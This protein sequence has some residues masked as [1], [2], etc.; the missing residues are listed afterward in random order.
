MGWNAGEVYR[1]AGQYQRAIDTFRSIPHMSPSVHAET[2]ACLVGLG[3]LDEARAEMKKFHQLA[4]Q[5]MVH[6][7]QTETAWRQYWYEITPYEHDEDFEVFYDQLLQAGLCDDLPATADHM[8]SIAVLPFENMSGDPEQE[9][10]ADGITTD[11]IATLSKFRHMRTISRYSTMQYKQHKPAIADIAKQ[12]DVRFILEGSVRKSKDRIRVNAELID[13]NDEQ[14][15][16]NE[17]YDRDLDDLFA[18]Q[19]EITR[20]IALAMKVQFDDGDMALHRSQGVTDIRAWELVMAAVDLQDTYI[21]ENILEA[22]GMARKSIELDPGYAYAWV[23]LAWTYWQEAYSGWSDSIEDLI[24]EAEKANRHALQLDPEYGEVWSQAGLIHIM[25]HEP[26][27]AI[28]ACR[29]AID[30]EPGNAEVQALAAFAYIFAGDYELGRH[31]YQNMF[32]LCPIR[33]N[34]YYLIGAQLEKVAGNL[35]KAAEIYQQG[36]DVEPDSPLCRFYLLDV[37]CDKGDQSSA[38]RLADEIRAL[39]KAVTGRGLVQ[40]YSYDRTLRDRVRA[41]FESYELF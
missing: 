10:F 4:Q 18:V 5:Q 22:R 9:F 32:K 35:D 39:D 1:M 38:R 2:S 6:Y 29:K 16:W 30:L 13:S 27:P 34:W 28:E 31:H 33:P 12:Q 20:H 41:N 37:M 15:L 26:E 21:R 24:A 40:A 36:I 25:K 8:P 3:Q 11:I 14:I 19:D 7:P 17:R 23:A